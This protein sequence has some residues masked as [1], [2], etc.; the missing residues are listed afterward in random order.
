MGLPSGLTFSGKCEVEAVAEGKQ[1][2][3]NCDRDVGKLTAPSG[4]EAGSLKG[5][6]QQVGSLLAVTG[7]PA[8]LPTGLGPCWLDLSRAEGPV[9]ICLNSYNTGQMTDISPFSS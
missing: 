3:Q 2:G 8:V 4:S 6:W 9:D 7:V 5:S 1:E